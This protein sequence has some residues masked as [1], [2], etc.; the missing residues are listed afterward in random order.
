MKLK[1]VICILIAI[2]FFSCIH[3]ESKPDAL[4]I[5]HESAA[6]EPTQKDSIKMTSDQDDQTK[7]ILV[8]DGSVQ[9]LF[10]TL[11]IEFSLSE[12]D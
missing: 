3:Q 4:K 5:T 8:V 2:L 1:M 12:N 6:I 9:K 11:S 10:D 7:D